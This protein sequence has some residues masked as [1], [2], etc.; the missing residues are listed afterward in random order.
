MFFCQSEIKERMRKKE[1]YKRFSPTS[2]RSINKRYENYKFIGW[3]VSDKLC[4][5]MC[6]EKIN[7]NKREEEI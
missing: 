5:K 3:V 6:K 2:F 1:N 4:A 7:K